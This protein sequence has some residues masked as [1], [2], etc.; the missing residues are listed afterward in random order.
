[1]GSPEAPFV[2]SKE[3]HERLLIGGVE[4]L[5]RKLGRELDLGRVHS[6]KFR[7]TLATK[8]I[9]KG[10]PIEQVQVLLGHKNRYHIKVCNGRPAQRQSIP[11]QI[12]NL[13]VVFSRQSLVL[14]S[15]NDRLD[16]EDGSGGWINIHNVRH[17]HPV[18]L[19]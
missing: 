3:P 2:S 1:M 6:H 16:I 9:D 5:L 4:A 8:A 17:V 18:L 11:P 14:P 7:R 10:M 15:T 19:A 13:D 12:S